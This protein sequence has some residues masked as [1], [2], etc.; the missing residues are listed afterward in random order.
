MLSLIM[1][2]ALALAQADPPV[3][4]DDPTFG[5]DKLIGLDLP[6]DTQDLPTIVI[7]I[8]N[9]VLGLLALIAIVIILIAG[10]EWMTAGGSEEKVKT[11]QNRLKYGLFGLVIVFLAYGIATWVLNTL[12]DVATG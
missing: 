3:V 2:P 4:T 11:A 6:S 8:I 5:T 10:F 7:N 9:I 12:S 1:M